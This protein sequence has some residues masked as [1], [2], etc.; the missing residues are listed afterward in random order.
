M[1]KRLLQLFAKFIASLPAML[2]GPLTLATSL[3]D[4]YDH[5]GVHR[6]KEE[7][8]IALRTNRFFGYGIR[9][10]GV[11]KGYAKNGSYIVEIERDPD[12]NFS[13]WVMGAYKPS[14]KRTEK[15][16]EHHFKWNIEH[17]FRAVSTTN[18]EIVY[19]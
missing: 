14:G 2:S 5:N 4:W 6:Y 7:T 8:I 1:R 10:V 12:G 3:S 13:D 11:I 19:A 16:L 9:P 15:V 17:Q 18:P